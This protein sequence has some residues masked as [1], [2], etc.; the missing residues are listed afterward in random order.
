MTSQADLHSYHNNERT[1]NRNCFNTIH[2]QTTRIY[3]NMSDI[4]G[5][6]DLGENG[7]RGAVSHTSTQGG[8][9]GK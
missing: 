2:K 1:A 6:Y 5:T 4:V 7:R 8:Q 9:Q 3:F